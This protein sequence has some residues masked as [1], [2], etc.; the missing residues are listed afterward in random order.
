MSLKYKTPVRYKIKCELFGDKDG[1][2]GKDIQS[3]TIFRTPITKTSSFAVMSVALRTKLYLSLEEYTQATNFITI[4]ISIY[5]VKNQDTMRDINPEEIRQFCSK[6]YICI[7]IEPLEHVRPHSP[8]VRTLLYLVNPVL[9]YMNNTN[10]YNK[11]HEDM[12][13]FDAIEDYESWCKKTFGDTAFQFKKIGKDYEKNDHNYEQILIRQQNDLLVPVLLL[14]EY[15]AWHS[16]GYYFFDD[17]RITDDDSDLKDI[18]AWC[19]NLGDFEKFEKKDIREEKYRDILMGNRF[20]KTQVL[21]DTFSDLYQKSTSLVVKGYDRQFA[22]RKATEDREIPNISSKL[23]GTGEGGRLNNIVSTLSRASK[24]PTEE[25]ILYAPDDPKMAEYRFQL[26]GKLLSGKMRSIMTYYLRDCHLDFF[27]FNHRYNLSSW[28]EKDFSYVPISIVN[29][30]I[31]DSGQ[32]PLMTH[33]AK[34]QVI[35]YWPK[36]S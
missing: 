24:P 6:N 11:I 30:F 14:N 29:M 35:K 9:F 32:V 15:K 25:T 20:Q 13:A 19:V 23:E 5:L 18:T 34:Y 7:H 27:Q 33:N 8:Y 26:V 4:P 3:F 22:F 12:T 36:D 17:F 1:E 31:R 2:I 28:D 16:Y 10:G 21:M